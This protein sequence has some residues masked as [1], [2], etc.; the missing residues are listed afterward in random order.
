MFTITLIC[1]ILT[2]LAPRIAIW[3]H[4]MLPAF[5]ML[6]VVFAA[7]VTLTIYMVPFILVLCWT[8][9]DKTF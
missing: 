3:L 4:Q 1:F 7:L 8:L 2:P 6:N 5:L 9:L